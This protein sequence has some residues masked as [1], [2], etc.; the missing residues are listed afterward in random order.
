[1][2]IERDPYLPTREWYERTAE[3]MRKGE[4]IDAFLLVEYGSRLQKILADSCA[5]F[6]CQP[7]H[8][9][10]VV[11]RFK[12]EIEEREDIM[13]QLECAMRCR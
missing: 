4:K 11:T 3:S 8:L 9:V 12:R 2:E 10:R 1:M 5:V 13:M 6:R 7:E